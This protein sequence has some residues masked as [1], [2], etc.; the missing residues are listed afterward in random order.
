MDTNVLLPGLLMS[1]MCRDV[2]DACL[3]SPNR[4]V[5]LSEHILQ[6]FARQAQAKFHVLEERVKEAVGFLRTHVELVHPAEV[7]PGA[8]RDPDDLPI[9]GTLLA[10]GADCLVTGDADLLELREFQGVPILSP[11]GF[12]QHLR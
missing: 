5:F 11:R 10:A 8:C 3:L 2:V 12:Y 4:Q 9:L 6:E 7:P 1:G